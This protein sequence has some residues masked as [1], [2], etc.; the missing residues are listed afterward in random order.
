MPAPVLVRPPAPPIVPPN[1]VLLAVPVVSV[2]EPRVTV[3]PA[4][5]ARSLMVAPEVV[6]EMSNLA[7][8]P[9]R[10]TPLEFAIEALFNSC[11]VPPPTVVAPV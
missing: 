1:V 11:N 6:P 4:T 9:V 3:V 7:P 10:L 8:E 2:L 5:P